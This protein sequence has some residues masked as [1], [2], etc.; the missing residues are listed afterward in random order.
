[1]CVV[2]GGGGGGVGVG[3]GKSKSMSLEAPEWSPQVA[4]RL[5]VPPNRRRARSPIPQEEGLFMPIARIHRPR[6]RSRQV[7]PLGSPR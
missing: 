5:Q 6:D 1:M 2:V 4:P 7:Q 3:Y